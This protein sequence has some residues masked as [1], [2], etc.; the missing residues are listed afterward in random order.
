MA[1]F[2]AAFDSHWGVAHRAGVVVAHV[3][4]IGHT[5]SSKVT[6]AHQVDYVASR[7]IGAGDPGGV[8]Y[9]ARVKQVSNAERL[10]F[11]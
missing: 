5:I 6:A 9:D 10:A 7:C 4:N 11:T 8:G 2:D 1:H 3:S